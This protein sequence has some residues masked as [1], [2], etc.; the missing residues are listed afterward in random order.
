MIAGFLE[1]VVGASV[2]GARI[3][4][5]FFLLLA[6]ASI[7]LAATQLSVSTD[8]GGLF[9]MKL[10]WK[11]QEAALKADF[12]QFT[13]LIVAVIDA[14]IPEEADVTAHGLAA[15]LAPDAKHF[16]SVREPENSPYL[17]QE[18]LLFL[19]VPQLQAVLDN[20]VDAEPFL[21]QLV[22]DPS[23]RGL[24]GALGLIAEGAKHGQT[25]PASFDPAFAA[26]HQTM[27]AALAGHAQPLSWQTLL[28]G[29]A[30]N[31]AGPDRIVLLQPRLD[32]HSVEPGGAATAAMRAAA[33]QLPYVRN[34]D[35]HV[36][37]TGDEPLADEEFSAA[38]KGAVTGLVISLLLVMLWLFLALRSWRLILPVLL[39][40]LLGLALTTGFAAEAVGTLNLI[41]VAFAILF[42]G[43]AVDF[44]IQFTVR[45]REMRHV[46]R[47]SDGQAGE[48]GQA[49][50]LTARRVGIQVLIASLATA[51]G[52][53]A[54][55]PTSFR[56]V[57]ELGL[58]AGAGML[59]AFV[60]TV[61]FL[62]AM[63]RLMHPRA[64]GQE[65][66]FAGLAPVD[67]FLAAWRV[68][69]VAVFGLLFVAGI[70]L[71]T[72]LQF[73]SNTLH[74]KSPNSEAVKTLMRLLRNPVTNPF[75]VS[76]IRPDVAQAASLAPALDRL[77][78]VDHTVN[79]LSFVPQDQAAKLAAVADAATVLSPVI[80]P[81][82]ALPAPD[83]A[84]IKASARTAAALLLPV[85][86]QLPAG[87][88][89]RAIVED[90]Q[91][92][93]GA[94]DTAVMAA[95]DA[96][97]RFLPMQLARLRL[98]LTAKSVTAADIPADLRRDWVT[99]EGRARIQ[100]VP[101]VAVS[102]GSSLARFVAQV[103]TVAPDAGGP[104][105]AIAATAATITGAFIQAGISAVLAIAVI[106]VLALRG[107]RDAALVLAP[108]LLSAAMTGLIVV[109]A[110][111]DLNY[112]NVIALP[113][114]LG[115]GVS[116]NIYF[117]MN[118]RAGEPARLASPTA[119]AVVF[120]ALTTGTAF[121][122]LAVSYHPGTASMGTLLLISLGCT[123]LSTLVC[124]PAM[125]ACLRLPDVS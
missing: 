51:S 111:M 46:L 1:R 64:E 93:Q 107:V 48:T 28:A 16:K 65:I 63:L 38:A 4:V 87:N 68:P 27:A 90:L 53:L 86:P 109:L 25:P 5:L 105:V 45:F 113:L 23:A 58:I 24:F 116:F 42:V 50:R 82:P 114:L 75:T 96:L 106:L 10:P 83:A 29:P 52:F 110:G 13:S 32:F 36:H 54:F 34:G 56:G 78:L 72:R 67:R 49:L 7:A 120:S 104:A 30:A 91:A 6:A 9:S 41:S 18:G 98:A 21:G 103:K 117:V 39:T 55:V 61:T 15:A 37:I 20:T 92:L 73:D 11:Q 8:I 66:G 124:V 43:I 123:L 125:L 60:C 100:A 14:R 95:N 19:P 80:Q 62:P 121:G 26:F 74:T 70:G 3:V 84:A 85:L 31:L 47:D 22:A 108:L 118:W 112:A 81:P 59:I 115:V 99:P 2:A 79:L 57:A 33:A 69:V 71:S 44:A 12:P 35:A 101:K 122:S 77:P 76:I 94:P 97:V 17:N 102:Q 88:P 40:L 119:R 89:L